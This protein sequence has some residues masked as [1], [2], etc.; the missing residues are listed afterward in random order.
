VCTLSGDG[1]AKEILRLIRAGKVERKR[2]DAELV[3]QYLLEVRFAAQPRDWGF[4][5]TSHWEL[6]RAEV[7]G[8][9]T[10]V[11]PE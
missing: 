6:L 2:Q 5:A 10:P 3:L 7:T 11:T 4:A 1:R 8:A 9:V